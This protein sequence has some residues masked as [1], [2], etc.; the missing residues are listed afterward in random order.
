[1]LILWDSIYEKYN[2]L[3]CG[4]LCPIRDLTATLTFTSGALTIHDQD[5]HLLSPIISSVATASNL[6][7]SGFPIAKSEHGMYI[8]RM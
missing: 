3:N 4:W 5:I 2:N 7:L 6:T 1:M 8:L